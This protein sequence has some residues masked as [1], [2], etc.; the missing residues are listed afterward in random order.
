M[1]FKLSARDDA[2]LAA[3]VDT[4][5]EAHARGELKQGAACGAIM[6]LVAAAASD[7]QAV[8]RAWCS[9]DFVAEWKAGE[10]AEGD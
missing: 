7:E 8:I 3:I 6:Q 1:A 2:A 4:I 10:Q 5:L 9:P